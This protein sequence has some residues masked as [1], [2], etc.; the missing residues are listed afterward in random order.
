M[1][2][3][4]RLIHLAGLLFGIVHEVWRN[5]ATVELHTL[6]N[7]NGSIHTLGLLN[8]D[9][10]FLLDGLHSLGDELADFLVVVGRNAGNILD[11]G[12]VVTN[13]LRL[14]LDTV[15]YSSHGL[16]DTT[17]QVHWVG[18][19]GNIL[20]TY[21]NHGLGKN[22]S[23]SCTIT[24]LVAGLGGNILDELCAHVL[25]WILELNLLGNGNTVLGDLRSTELLVND[26]VATLG[27]KSNFHCICK[28]VNARLQ[29]VS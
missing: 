4:Q 6:D 20:E 12:V 29:H 8:G 26:H 5:V 21:A 15:N 16:V 17:L 18:T 7:I 25:E 3:N 28:L 10:A 27:A 23:G 2:E 9:D 14:S 11:L 13:L 22:S 1:D 19:C 24:S